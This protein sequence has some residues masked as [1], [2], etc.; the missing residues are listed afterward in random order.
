[1]QNARSWM[2]F[3]DMKKRCV[4]PKMTWKQKHMSY[5]DCTFSYECSCVLISVVSAVVQDVAALRKHVGSKTSLIRFKFLLCNCF[6]LF[7]FQHFGRRRVCRVTRI[8]NSNPAFFLP[9]LFRA[10]QFTSLPQRRGWPK[11]RWW[12]QNSYLHCTLSE[13]VSLFLII[14][15]SA[16]WPSSAALRQFEHFLVLWQLS[17]KIGIQSALSNGDSCFSI[18]RISVLLFCA[19]SAAGRTR[20]GC[21]IHC[22]VYTTNHRI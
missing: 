14:R 21:E 1:M 11:T 10:F 9:M 13:N 20:D 16:I 18:I 6:W 7:V 3:S 15:I 12:S 17:S 19:K 5:P 4:L 8:P 22:Q 2:L